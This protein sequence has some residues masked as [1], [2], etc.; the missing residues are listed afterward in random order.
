VP[1]CDEGKIKQSKLKNSLSYLMCLEYLGN[2]V[3]LLMAKRKSS[4]FG[5]GGFIIHSC[6]VPALTAPVDTEEADHPVYNHTLPTMADPLAT[7]TSN[8][9]QYKY[10]FHGVHKQ[11]GQDYGEL[12]IMSSMARSEP[13]RVSVTLRDKTVLSSRLPEWSEYY[14]YF[15]VDS[16]ARVSRDSIKNMQLLCDGEQVC[17]PYPSDCDMH[18][19]LFCYRFY[20]LDAVA[21]VTLFLTSNHLVPR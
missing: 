18:H 3:P 4:K 5:K 12:S 14:G 16:S 10:K 2:F 19:V 15:M 13:R 8:S 9:L 7:V 20:S 6:S 1:F 17:S 21:M 11:V